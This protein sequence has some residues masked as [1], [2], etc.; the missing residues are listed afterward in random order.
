MGLLNILPLPVR[1]ALVTAIIRCIVPFVPAFTRV[2]MRNLEIAFPD[3]DASWRKGILRQSLSSLARLLVDFA[4]LDTLDE[5]WVKEHVDCPFLDRFREIKRAHPGKGVMLAT[6]HLGSFELL[7]HCVA[8]FGF[9]ISF[10]VRPFK[11]KRLNEWWRQ[12]REAAGHRAISR[13][14]AFKEIGR[15]L[16]QGRDVA[17]L[18]DQNV[19]RNHAVFV[20]W[21]GYPAATTKTVALAAIRQQAPIVVASMQYLGNDRYHIHA[22][23][24][25]FQAL[26]T[27]DAIS[28]DRKIEV[29]TATISKHYENMIRDNPGEWFWMHR[30]WKTRP[31]EADPSLY[32]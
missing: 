29:I 5:H 17:V 15:D 4:R 2:A 18:F 28:L 32:D 23:E 19:T 31:N 13:A 27:D 25:D 1:I 9:S 3:R 21:F 7:A 26:Y 20:D 11:L 24:A 30:R 8:R 22:C 10:V 6:G 14:G 16:T 12:K